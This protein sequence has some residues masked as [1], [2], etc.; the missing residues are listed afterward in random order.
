VKEMEQR[1]SEEKRKGEEAVEREKAKMR[2]LVKA[3]A[4]REEREAEKNNFVRNTLAGSSGKD[5]T[6]ITATWNQLNKSSSVRS[7]TNNKKRR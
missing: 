5:S 4:E 3:L 1:I 7:V 6:K 2:K